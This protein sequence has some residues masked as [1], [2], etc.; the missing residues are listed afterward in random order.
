M[1]NEKNLQV[2]EVIEAVDFPTY[3]EVPL[4]IP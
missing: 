4:S 3:P 2:D 1:Y